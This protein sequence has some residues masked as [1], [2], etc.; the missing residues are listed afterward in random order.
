[1]ADQR[2]LPPRSQESASSYES[3][4]MLQQPPMP[5][6][7]WLI[8]VAFGLVVTPFRI[9]L[10]LFNTYLPIFRD[11][12]WEQLTSAGSAAYHPLWGPIL[13]FEIV[14]N[15]LLLALGAVTLALFFKKSRRTPKFTIALYA[16]GPAFLLADEWLGNVIPA[17]ANSTDSTNLQEAIRTTVLACIWIPYFLVSDRV[18]RTFTL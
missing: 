13:V 3:P 2:Y 14:G 16:A 5:I 15:V 12:H 11:G 1:M 18:K 9:V 6:G 4:A 10:H 17:V 7:G 8:L